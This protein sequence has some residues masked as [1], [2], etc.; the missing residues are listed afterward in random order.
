MA[1]F[2][3][4]AGIILVI[5]VG[6]VVQVI[7]SKVDMRDTPSKAVVEFSKSYFDLD[8]SMAKRICKKDLLSKDGNLVDQYLYHVAQTAKERGFNIDFLKH[9]LYDIETETISKTKN[10]AQIRITGTIRV[11]INS[12]YPVIAQL[13]N[14]GATHKVDQIIHVI[15]ENGQWKV[16]GKL[17]SLT[18]A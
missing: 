13:F 14:I 7:F 18:S 11:A 10:D 5:I 16:C 8:K 6:I 17:F 4:S 12:V 1:H 3:R 15:K 2:S 9:K